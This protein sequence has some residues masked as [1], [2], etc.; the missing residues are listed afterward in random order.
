MKA[1]WVL[2][3][4]LLATA[5]CASVGGDPGNQQSDSS[6]SAPASPD[7][8]PVASPPAPQENMGPRLVQPATGGTPGMAI[9]LGGDLYLPLTGGP[10][11]IGIP[12]TP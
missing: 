5:G 12:L 1:S 9:P 4:A 3:P 6:F 2:I 8:T 11:V 10:P 7:A